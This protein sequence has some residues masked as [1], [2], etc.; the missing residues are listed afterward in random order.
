M[1]AFL[2]SSL[3]FH[4]SNTPN[5]VD[6]PNHSAAQGRLW[7]FRSTCV[8]NLVVRPQKVPGD[9]NFVIQ[10]GGRKPPSTGCRQADADKSR[11]RG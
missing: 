1:R 10:A 6:N 5:V 4:V 9:V 11:P 3:T 2:T 7:H 8:L